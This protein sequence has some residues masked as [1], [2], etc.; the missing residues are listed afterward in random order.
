MEPQKMSE[1]DFTRTV[2]RNAFD[3]WF[4]PEIKRRQEA[5]TLPKPFRVWAAQ[6]I[7]DLQG[8]PRINFNEELQGHIE[9]ESDGSL[10]VGQE[11][12]LAELGDLK[13][14]HI[15]E[16]HPD[17]GHVTAIQHKKKW[18]LFFDFRYN[19]SRISLH[20]DVSRQFLDA[21]KGAAERGHPNAAI[22]NLFAAVELMAKSYLLMSPDTRLLEKTRHRFVD[23][24]FNRYG[25]HGNVP[26]DFVRL[27]N[28]LTKLRNTAR[29]PSAP[30]DIRV[31][32]IDAWLKTADEMDS[33][34]DDARPKLDV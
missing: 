24:E 15:A 5:G 32:Q 31:S 33:H 10:K 7:L 26:R 28:A 34:L 1:Q 22:E 18:Y 17:A 14:I 13:G 20:L 29:F 25:K 12:T 23:K 27:F 9:A 30:L 21:A 8:P 6:V 16:S 11:F 19:A 4:E 3:L 2:L